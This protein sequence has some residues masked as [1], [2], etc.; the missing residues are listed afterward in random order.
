MSKYVLCEV[1]TTHYIKIPVES[2]KEELALLEAGYAL[3]DVD[4]SSID[5]KT[6]QTDGTI[7][8]D[9]ADDWKIE[10]YELINEA[11]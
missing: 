3:N 9:H 2:D 11:D 7:H 6:T 8:I 1:K 10:N 5:L 4:I